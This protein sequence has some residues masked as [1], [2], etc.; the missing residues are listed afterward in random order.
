MASPSYQ[1]HSDSAYSSGATSRTVTKPASTASG[2]L[3]IMN[4]VL[5]TD[6]SS[7]LAEKAI[8][9]PSGFVEI[10][11]G[12][13]SEAGEE[14]QFA[15]AWK[16][17]GGA[18]PADYTA[19]WTGSIGCNAR[20]TRVTGHYTVTPIDAASDTN[21]AG[22]VTTSTSPSL[23]AGNTDTL[24]LAYVATYFAKDVSFHASFT[25]VTAGSQSPTQGR[26]AVAGSGATGTFA[27]TWTGATACVNVGILI[28]SQADPG[29]ASPTSNVLASK[30]LHSL[31]RGRVLR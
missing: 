19:S 27:H 23:T 25:E 12:Y 1:N 9:W 11:S 10:L 8:T 28:A 22:K 5:F 24:Y 14:V 20:V 2:D 6:A 4:V 30:T 29:G 15:A 16:E 21:S 13:Q 3:L 17:A 7:L 31:A 26:F 18:E